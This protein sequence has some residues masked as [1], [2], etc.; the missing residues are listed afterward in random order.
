M[1]PDNKKKYAARVKEWSQKHDEFLREH[2]YLRKNPQRLAPGYT[3][4]GK[5]EVKSYGAISGAY[6]NITDPWHELRDKQAEAMYT[7]FKNRDKASVIGNI[8]ISANV[9]IETATKAYEHLFEN[10]YELE[11]GMKTFD[12]DYDM[13]QSLQRLLSNTN[14]QKHDVILIL[15]EAMEHDI[16]QLQGLPYTVAHEITQRKYNYW[17]ALIRWK[18]DN[19][20]A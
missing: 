4:T 18:E 20:Y 10:V 15:H 19:G 12:P 16:M 7:E 5:P 6:N 9:D 11:G 2:D 13:A 1:D 8:A 17:E 3:G 14:V